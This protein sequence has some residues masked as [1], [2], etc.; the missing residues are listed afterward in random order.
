MIPER[1]KERPEPFD[2]ADIARK[3]HSRSGLRYQSDLHD[4]EW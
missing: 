2:V 4:N 1:C 3:R